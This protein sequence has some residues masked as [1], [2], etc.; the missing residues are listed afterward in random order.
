MNRATP[1]KAM[2]NS[3]ATIKMYCITVMGLMDYRF[4]EMAQIQF[5]SFCPVV[6]E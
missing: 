1:A 6:L 4:G 2:I 5:S 3:R